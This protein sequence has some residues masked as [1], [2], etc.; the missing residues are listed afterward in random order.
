MMKRMLALLLAAVLLVLTGCGEKATE[1][2][3]TAAPTATP[4]PT[5]TPTPAPTLPPEQAAYEAATRLMLNGEYAAAAEAFA[6]WPG[7]SDAP[8]MAIYCRGL[9]CAESGDYASAVLAFAALDSFKDSAVKVDYYTG[10]KHQTA[11]EAAHQSGKMARMEA[12]LTDLDLAGEAFEQLTYLPDVPER[13]ANIAALR[14]QMTAEVA[15]MRAAHTYEAI[16]PAAD[17]RFLVRRD[18]LWGVI[19]ASGEVVHPFVWKA[20]SDYRSMQLYG[21][22]F[23]QYTQQYEGRDWSTGVTRYSYD[24][25]IQDAEGREILRGSFNWFT[26]DEYGIWVET[27]EG[28]RR[29]YSLTGEELTTLGEAWLI[30]AD[31][32]MRNT[33]TGWEML[34]ASGA[35]ICAGAGDLLDADVNGDTVWL[36]IAGENGSETLLLTL[37]GE[38]MLRG[39]SGA[40]LGE[41]P[42]EYAALTAAD[43]TVAVYGP[44]GQKRF[45]SPWEKIVWVGEGLFAVRTEEGTGLADLQGNLVVPCTINDSTNPVSAFED[46][47]MIT[48]WGVCSS[49]GGYF[50]PPQDPWHW[51][52]QG[53]FVLMD[54]TWEYECDQVV[55]RA[56]GELVAEVTYGGSGKGSICA[57]GDYYAVLVDDVITICDAQGNVVY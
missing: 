46:G 16:A 6:A 29:G 33:E 7:Y 32:A 4:V 18:G 47:W 17:G 5:A 30:T 37:S 48:T 27:M 52:R 55:F 53:G 36:Q 3:P 41:A 20:E 31:C 44:D 45:D 35:V 28:V 22:L 10:V 25:L 1:P 12:A 14:T 57:S 11:A 24:C 54:P 50:S 43:G 42:M 26:V 9:A 15:E 8:Q 40:L 39:G 51:I 49:Q 19:D 23:V 34:D 38:E 2:V 21:D 13:L 56:S